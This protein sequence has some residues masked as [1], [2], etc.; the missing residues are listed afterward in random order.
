M[1]AFLLVPRHVTESPLALGAAGGGGGGGVILTPT[2][3]EGGTLQVM[4]YL[5]DSKSTPSP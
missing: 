5:P 3:E 4:V 1:S 2:M